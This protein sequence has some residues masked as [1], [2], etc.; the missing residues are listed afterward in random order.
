[1]GK[2]N[3]SKNNFIVQGGI[4]AI[5][6]IIV[7]LIGL[8]RRIPLA[9][10]I[11]DE[12]NG[13]YATAYEVYAIILL[14]SSYSLPLAVSKM[15]SARVG[16]GQYKNAERIFKS[17][18]LFATIVGSIASIFVY[19]TADSLSILMLE[20]MS[21]IALRMLAPALLLVAVMG[22]FRGYFQGLGTMMPTAVSQ[23]IEQVFLVIAS[24]TGAYIF[25]NYGSKVAA[26]LQNSS[27]EASYGAAGGTI[28]CSIGAIIGLA[29]LVFVYVI[30]APRFK[31]QIDR[32]QTKNLESYRT[33]FKILLLTI[34]PVILNT[35][36][37]NLC[38]IVNQRV[39][40]ASMVAKGLEDL[41]TLQWGVF[42]GKYRVIIN[43]P[44]ALASAMSASTIPTLVKLIETKDFK[45]ARSKIKNVIRVTMIIAI[46]CAVGIGVLAKPIIYLLF[47]T[48][49]LDMAAYMLN[50]GAVSVVLYAF[51][52][53]TNGVLQGINRMRIPVR[54]SFISLIVEI[55]FLYLILNFTNIGV[56][57]VV[58]ANIVFSG[59]MC[60][61][62]FFA[63]RKHLKY[64]QELFKTFIIP[65]VSAIIMGI[66]IFVVCR[67]FSLFAGD[68]VIT[69]VGV[70]VG[71]IMYFI[72]LVLLKGIG[73]RELQMIPMGTKCIPILKKFN[74]LPKE[75]S[76]ENE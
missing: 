8:V 6:G 66:V 13:Y 57:G 72:A 40:N 64:K 32:D 3:K 28:G 26:L 69:F 35:A 62:N 49:E 42:T 25:S 4:L 14:L 37:Y 75:D 47:S 11:G 39:F 9:H 2:K 41:K 21:A 20:P 31:R 36:V 24:L 23:I 45:Q 71:S 65:G 29:F 56:Y 12:G 60:V 55:V 52:T 38:N 19:F 48:G 58:L 61:L 1:M 73:E 33:I 43:I 46:P 67:V 10:I 34:V 18:L 27:Y 5:A 70:I 53:L 59:L 15:V 50:I 51:S 44:I 17:S 30:Y 22:V 7:R 76:Y 16:K 74:L 68:L 54:N 63:I